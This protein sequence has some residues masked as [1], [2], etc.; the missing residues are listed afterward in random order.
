MGCDSDTSLVV[1]L[2]CTRLI[3]AKREALRKSGKMASMRV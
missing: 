2:K 3:F 1:V